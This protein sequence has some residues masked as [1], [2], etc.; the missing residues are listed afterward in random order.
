MRKIIL[1]IL[2]MSIIIS[3]GDYRKTK[4]G[5]LI[6]GNSK[7]IFNGADKN[8]NDKSI[9]SGFV[10]SKDTKE[11]IEQ[12]YVKIGTLKFITDKNGYF[13]ANVEPGIYS[14][15][16]NFIGNCEEKIADLKVE[17]NK[18]IIIVFELGTAVIQ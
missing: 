2:I 14:V 18:R 15:S 9:V 6:K 5:Y 17:K 4:S 11:F 3:C 10:Y 16:A 1:L 13:I 12:A 8:L 7:I